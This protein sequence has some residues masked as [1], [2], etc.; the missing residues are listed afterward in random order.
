MAPS[1]LAGEGGGE[2]AKDAE[3]LLYEAANHYIDRWNASE[4]EL[5]SLLH[6]AIARPIPTLVTLGGVIDVTYLSTCPTGSPGRAC[7]WMRTSEG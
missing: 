3:R 2:G 5:A 6:L 4:N 1:H 7:I